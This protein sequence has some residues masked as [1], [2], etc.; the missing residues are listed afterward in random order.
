MAFEKFGHFFVRGFAGPEGGHEIS[1]VLVELCVCVTVIAL[2]IAR[3][4]CGEQGCEL[5]GLSSLSIG[6]N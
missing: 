1:V 6:R 2:G 4:D 3:W 5:V